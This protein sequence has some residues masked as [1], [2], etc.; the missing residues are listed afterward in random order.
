M[1]IRAA[2]HR[3]LAIVVFLA[4]FMSLS[5]TVGHASTAPPMCAIENLSLGIGQ[6]VSPMT[7]E[8]GNIYTLTNRSKIACFLLGYPGV[9]FYDKTR[10]VLPFKYTQS[11]SI[12]MTH[13]APK[14]ILLLIGA[15]AYFLVAGSA[16]DFG[17]AIE[18]VTIR[19][20]PPNAKKPLI[21]R[22]TASPGVGT[23]TY[24]KDAPTDRAQFLDVSPVRADIHHL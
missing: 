14:L 12:Y 10:H 22:A 3:W 4:T 6:R 20:Y 9:S 15:R 2:G 5:G 13:T 16:C 1:S 19:V 23:I 7:Q 24:C 8:H 18:A 21:G 17:T 11:S